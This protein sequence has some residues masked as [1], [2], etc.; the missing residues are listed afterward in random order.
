MG[1]VASRASRSASAAGAMSGEW[2]A[3]PTSSLPTARADVAGAA[4]GGVDR[5][6]AAGEHDLAGRVVVGERQLE[7]GRELVDVVALAAEHGDH[8]AGL[9][10]GGV[11]HRLRAGADEPHAVLEVDRT[12]GRQR[13]VLA[14]RV[15]GRGERIG[16]VVVARRP[17]RPSSTET[18]RAAAC[19][20]PRRGC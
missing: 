9:Q 15:A 1:S 18:A 19:A 7:V 2:N 8:A 4:H 3:P 16:L 11:G 20:F 12:G 10:G 13:G 14:E 5:A 6:H 17:L